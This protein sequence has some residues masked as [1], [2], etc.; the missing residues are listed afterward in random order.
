MSRHQTRELADS[1]IQSVACSSE[2]QIIFVFAML[3]NDSY[4]V[5]IG[6][7]KSNRKIVMTRVAWI[8][9]VHAR[10]D[11]SA[12]K[13]PRRGI[14]EHVSLDGECTQNRI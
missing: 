3:E 13:H 12:S 8:A 10:S 5:L 4:Y 9:G 11:Q 1:W 6:D 7:S 2:L 14:Y